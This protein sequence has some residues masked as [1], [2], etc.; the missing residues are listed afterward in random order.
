MGRL[1]KNMTNKNNLNNEYKRLKRKEAYL[2]IINGFTLSMLEAQSIE[3]V[4]WAIAK[5]VVAKMGFVDCVVYLVENGEL[6]QKAAHGA[7][8]PIQMDILNPIIIPFGKGVVGTVAKTGIAE[9]VSNTENDERYIVDDKRRLSEITIPIKYKGVIIGVID[10]EHPEANFYTE[11]HKEI[12]TTVAAIS[13]T[14]IMHAQA[15][16]HLKSYQVN[17]QKEIELKTAELQQ[18]VINLKRSNFDL[19]QF[20]YAVSHDLKEPLRT[21]TS[22]LQ[23]LDRDKESEFSEQGKEFLAFTLTGSKRMGKLLDG[24]LEYSR[25]KQNNS[26]NK[27]VNVNDVVS[28]AEDNLLDLI[29]RKEAKVE[30]TNLPNI[31][32]NFIQIIQLFQNLIANA[33]KFHKEEVLPIVRIDFE[34][35][36][37]MAVFSVADNGIGIE[38]QFV[39][40]IFGLFNQ[41]NSRQKFEGSGIGLALCKR[42]VEYHGG[43][44]WVESEYGIGTTFRFSLPIIEN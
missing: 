22:Y 16:E 38:D 39:D 12:L 8:N 31:H 10:S 7:K 15:L 29:K 41:L 21:I 4:V 27:V 37:K 3:E 40:R 32:G 23:L 1:N 11:E 14:K 42:I 28:M 17:L 30:Y 33:I 43:E 5:N 25:L 6:I 9:I 34:I 35:K 26:M 2:E 18:T 44:I 24:L 20:A 36:E 19:E 13:A